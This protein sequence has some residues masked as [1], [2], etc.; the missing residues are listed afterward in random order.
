MTPVGVNA[1]GTVA[2][3]RYDSQFNF[4]G[5][6]LWSAGTTIPLTPPSNMTY[7]A[8]V[9]DQGTAVG[10]DILTRNGVVWQTPS[11]YT[12][13]ASP[14]GTFPPYPPGPAYMNILAVDAQGEL[15]IQ[16]GAI[17]NDNVYQAWAST[18]YGNGLHA[19]SPY[20]APL[21]PGLGGSLTL[22]VNN[23][24]ELFTQNPTGLPGSGTP[25]YLGPGTGTPLDF[26][27]CSVASDGSTVGT[28]TGGAGVLR[29]PSGAEGTI[30]V[31]P[32]CSQ[33]TY[34]NS[35]S[36]NAAHDVIGDAT[37]VSSLYS[38][39]T[40]VSIS[41]LFGPSSGWSAVTATDINDAGD[42]IGRGTLNGVSHGFLLQSSQLAITG[43]VLD[44]KSKPVAG[45]FVKVT[46]TDAQGATVNTTATTG[47]SGS[48]SV[49]L[50][51]GHYHFDAA[52][53]TPT[54]QPTGGRW[55][56]L[57]CPGTSSSPGTCDIT[58]SG[59]VSFGYVLPDLQTEALEITQGIQ[60]QA[61]DTPLSVTLPVLGATPGG[62]Y[63]GQPLIKDVAT[64]VRAYASVVGDPGA[65]AQAGT[66]AVLHAYSSAGGGLHELSGSP[67]PADAARTLQV[68]NSLPGARTNPTGAYTFTLPKAWTEGAPITLAAEI[69]PASNGVRPIHE[70]LSCAANDAFALT[71]IA[72]TTTDPITIR[73]FEIAYKYPLPG[74]RGF[75]FTPGPNLTSLLNR[76]RSLLPLAP[77]DLVIQPYYQAYV[78]MSAEV[79]QI[80]HDYR[81]AHYQL[82]KPDL[83]D[84]MAIYNCRADLTS[85]EIDVV[86]RQVALLHFGRS[87][88]FGFS[89][90]TQGVSYTNT[91]V[92]IIGPHTPARPLTSAL[93]ELLHQ[94]GFA[95]ASPCGGGGANGQVAV[96]WPPDQQ[97]F[98]HGIGLDRIPNSGGPGHYRIIAPQNQWYDL[99]SYCTNASDANAWISTDNWTKFVQLD[100]GPAPHAVV[101]AATAS[102]QPRMIVDAALFP[103]GRATVLGA[104]STS[105]PLTHSQGSGF[106]IKVLGRHGQTIGDVA[107]QP[108]LVKDSQ[109]V[110][111]LTA[112]VPSTGASKIELTHGSQIMASKR[113]PKVSPSVRLLTPRRGYRVVHHA[114]TIRWR[115]RGARGAPLTATVQYLSSPRQGWQ[116]LIA[117]LTTHSY[118]VPASLLRHA[119]RLRLRVIVGDGF[120]DVT[121]TASVRLH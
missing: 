19:L 79:Q 9:S 102:A 41:S 115:P 105:G 43:F 38:G 67:I 116:T 39:G 108:N 25:R 32:V 71:R 100:N 74:G 92:S 97:G 2:V 33:S 46:G 118:S 26:R 5:P 53:V 57:H 58:T 117:G 24:H 1:S 42:I 106:H 15:A 54:G 29:D 65:Q 76:G 89:P 47:P 31:V 55:T 12:T 63:T 111:F 84:C 44:T 60:N 104:S 121:A 91:G 96:P 113:R 52:T 59:Q 88:L 18:S 7:I 95:H 103:G 48:Y 36:V 68:G 70:C 110:L 77:N 50:S 90:I 73:P 6:A 49:T 13:F 28:G 99:M 51:P 4:L 34:Y 10:T 94:V 37:G 27:A 72:F 14:V 3:N 40:T 101:T 87:Y 8:G 109:G 35:V 98:I 66:I 21:G 93:H 20:G 114:L 22:G 81:L 85:A 56:T 61:W 82:V 120:S 112:T 75:K 17:Q 16:E 69:D 80:V 11:S 78:D 119:R 30:P 86:N 83:S 23:G 64:V 62:S 107:V 45:A